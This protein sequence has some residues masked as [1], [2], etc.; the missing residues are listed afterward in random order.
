[1][2]INSFKEYQNRYRRR[3]RLAKPSPIYGSED[4]ESIYRRNVERALVLCLG[5]LILLFHIFPASPEEK[6]SAESARVPEIEVVEIQLTAYNVVPPP[7]PQEPVLADAL[8]SL[9]IKPEP[10]SLEKP[11]KNLKLDLDLQPDQKL[12]AG[13]QMED[14]V[15]SRSTNASRGYAAASLNINSDFN[16]RHLTNS[17]LAFDVESR[18]STR[19]IV[20][21]TPENPI[22]LE[23]PLVADEEKKEV[24]GQ[25]SSLIELEDNQFLLK[26][27]ESTIGTNEYRLWNKINSALDRIN[28]NRYGSLPQNVRRTR[29]GLNV[30]FR[31]DNDSQHDIFWNRGGKLLIRVTGTQSLN[32]TAE[33]EKALKAL[34]DLTSG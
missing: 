12:L 17:D 30:S 25:E 31:Y 13:S 11:E 6:N 4:L 20:E 8:Q 22:I 19:K 16:L 2:V 15:Y 27:S 1:M 24:P 32:S 29:S 26:E 28:K 18:A 23:T 7:P 9:V 33:L 14:I 10:D 21:K 3:F 34:I 5:I